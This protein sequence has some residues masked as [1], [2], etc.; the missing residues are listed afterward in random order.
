M[1]ATL[2]E[3]RRGSAI[4]PHAAIAWILLAGCEDVAD[5]GDPVP[6]DDGR[7]D[8]HPLLGDVH[9]LLPWPS[10]YFL[11]ED[12][13]APTG[14]RV[15][16]GPESLP[17]SE[18]GV[19]TDPTYFNEK[20]GF[21][22]L[23]PLLAYVPDLSTT[24]L[25]SHTD[26]GAYA[27]DDASSV[28][29]DTET[30]ERIPHWCELDDRALDPARRALVIHPAI[31]LDHGRRYV[32]GLRNLVD[33]AGHGVEAP[34]TFA[35]LRDAVPY[36]DPDVDDLHDVYDSIVFPA[37]EAAG[38]ARRELTLAW[39]FK[40]VSRAT[41]QARMLAI[42]DDALARLPEGGP[43]YA[44]TSVVDGDCGAEGATV[45]R[46]VR[47]TFT[48]PL[49]LT[50]REPGSLFTR[51]EDGLP[52]ATGE[53]EVPFTVSVPCTLLD[54]PRPGLLVQYGHGLF[55]D[56]TQVQSGFLTAMAQRY[57][58]VTFAVD[59]TGMALA[60]TPAVLSILA[61]GL[62]AFASVPERSQQGW[63]EQ[64]YAGR[65]MLGPMASDPALTLDGTALVDPSC[66]VFYGLSQ[67]AILGAGYVAISPDVHRA[68]LGVGGSPFALLLPRSWDFEPYLQIIQALYADPID[69]A[70]FLGLMQMVWD[71]GET[72]AWARYVTRLPVD[73]GTPTK[74][75]LLQLAV[76][77][78]RVSTLGGAVA[79][80]ALDVALVT[81]A[82][83][84][85]WGLETRPA[86]FQ[87]SALV[88]FDY[89]V[90]EPVAQVPCPRETD[91]HAR[92]REEPAGQEQVRAF[93]EEGVVQHTCDGPCDP[94]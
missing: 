76:G 38:F 84:D 79:A 48:A 50:S 85:V 90:E 69:V 61:D 70:V 72:A 91:T 18:A 80:R 29:V 2:R 57:G 10:S 65:L 26:I 20:D 44:V 22:T 68:V 82:V 46:T 89:G 31:P 25:V 11:A 40:T 64:V 55:G 83:R 35:S 13:S 37:L 6:V 59:W 94:D 17:M 71:P 42:R 74:D 75:V 39:D 19:R 87:G 63:V 36:G 88:E 67:G 30:G 43:T 23:G 62:S 51:G 56:Q 53:V 93:L 60:D 58:W 45:G 7:S 4:P 86:P 81:P 77:D 28:I 54:D 16:F 66:L 33:T 21:S 14:Y 73:A 47:G 92:P 15:A 78:A 32:V 12:A 5:T 3:V 49:Y 1:R 9:C 34:G 52:Y 41:N 8:C 27:S 24:G